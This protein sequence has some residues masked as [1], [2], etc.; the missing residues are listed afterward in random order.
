MW[1]SNLDARSLNINYEL[2]VRFSDPSWLTKRAA[3][4]PKCS[5]ALPSVELTV[6]AR[7]RTLW[8]K[9]MEPVGLLCPR[10]DGSVWARGR[11]KLLALVRRDR[12][13]HATLRLRDRQAPNRVER[14]F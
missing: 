14:L 10:P 12:F 3:S 7:S 4:S 9:L 2:L 1:F 11:A 6:V 5:G 8:T 13:P